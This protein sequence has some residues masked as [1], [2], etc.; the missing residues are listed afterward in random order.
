MNWNVRANDHEQER[1]WTESVTADAPAQAAEL[2][3]RRTFRLVPVPSA[4]HVW[5]ASD[6]RFD[7]WVRPEHV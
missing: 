2:L 7:V 4:P 1:S 3:T 6:D 5:Q